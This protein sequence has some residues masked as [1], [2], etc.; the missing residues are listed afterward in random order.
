M[1][2]DTRSA[3]PDAGA[4]ALHGVALGTARSLRRV[5][6]TGALCVPRRLSRAVAVLA[7][8]SKKKQ[9]EVSLSLSFP[10]SLSLSL[11]RAWILR[12]LSLRARCSALVDF[13]DRTERGASFKPGPSK[14]PLKF[15]ERVVETSVSRQSGA[16]SRARTRTSQWRSIRRRPRSSESQTPEKAEILSSCTK[17]AR[18]RTRQVFGERRRVGPGRCFG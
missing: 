18:R 16:I 3:G 6:R 15:I 1:E 11:S 13:V 12:T 5:R 17:T 4:E 10:L 2:R 9:Q 7:R 8:F 14:I